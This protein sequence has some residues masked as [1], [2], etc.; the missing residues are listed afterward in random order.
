MRN[1]ALKFILKITNFPL[2]PFI[3]VFQQVELSSSTL[4]RLDFPLQ[5]FDTLV[6]LKCCNFVDPSLKRF[7]LA[8]PRLITC[9]YQLRRN[10]LCQAVND[11]RGETSLRP[12]PLHPR[13]TER[14]PAGRSHSPAGVHDAGHY[15]TEPPRVPL[16][17]P[18]R[19]IVR[20]Q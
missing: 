2:C 5:P 4:A 9:S 11:N 19:R 14:R 20:T 13:S 15:G 17:K 10:A 1:P 7:L 3:G 8:V 12:L 6:A 18:A 16:R